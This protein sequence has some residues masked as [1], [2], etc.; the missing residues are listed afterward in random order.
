MYS[1]SKEHDWITP[2]NYSFSEYHGYDFFESYTK[3]REQAINLIKELVEDAKKVREDQAISA[4]NIQKKIDEVQK[5]AQEIA[6]KSAQAGA[7]ATQQ[8][9]EQPKDPN[10]QDAQVIDDDQNK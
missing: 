3:N 6:Q 9:T 4:E 8:T 1:Y 5:F 2:I 7:W 10:N